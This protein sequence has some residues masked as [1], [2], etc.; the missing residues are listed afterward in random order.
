MVRKK[1]RVIGSALLV[2]TALMT[3]AAH[4][5]DE[6]L[7]EANKKTVLAFIVGFFAKGDVS[8]AEKFVAPDLIQH[9]P[10]IGDGRDA[11]IKAVQARRADK[12]APPPPAPGAEKVLNISAA[13][14]LV[15]IHRK[16]AIGSKPGAVVDIFRLKDGL[17]V[18]HWDIEQTVPENAVSQHPLF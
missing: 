16:T 13:D 10:N 14:D 2:T 15:W 5:H 3:G 18:E 4:A 11:L 17:I 12:S 9:N 6:S 8:A 1:L 7:Q